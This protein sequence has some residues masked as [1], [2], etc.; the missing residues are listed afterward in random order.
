MTT[1]DRRRRSAEDCGREPP[2]AMRIQEHASWPGLFE[3]S[4]HLQEDLGLGLCISMFLPGY[5][6]EVPLRIVS[7]RDFPDQ[8]SVKKF[9]R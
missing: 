6:P 4:M 7:R 8:V 9:S 1:C 3:A 2:A 5:Y